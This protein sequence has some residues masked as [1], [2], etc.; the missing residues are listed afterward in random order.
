MLFIQS[1]QLSFNEKVN[2]SIVL[3][4]SVLGIKLRTVHMQ[5]SPAVHH[6]LSHTQGCS[7][8]LVLS[9]RG[10]TDSISTVEKATLKKPSACQPSTFTVGLCSAVTF[11]VTL[12]LVT[13]CLRVG[14]L[15]FQRDSEVTSD[16]CVLS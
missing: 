16:F 5:V 14:R 12:S 15:A 10:T 1:L 3:A 11:I 2:E 13:V 6:S 9:L 4:Q 8:E 7:A